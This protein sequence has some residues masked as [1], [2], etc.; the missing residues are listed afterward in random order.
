MNSLVSRALT[1]TKHRYSNI[2]RELLG[3]VFGRVST[4]LY[5]VETDNHL[6]TNIQKKTKATMSQRLHR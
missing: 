3:A 4:S 2:E 6:L 5:T 1:E